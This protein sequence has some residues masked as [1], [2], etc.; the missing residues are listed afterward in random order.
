IGTD[1]TGT[2]DLGNGT[3][4]VRIQNSGGN[5]VGCDPAPKV[6]TLA[7]GNLIS[8]NNASGIAMFNP[9]F[10]TIKGN[11][12]GTD[13]S[14]TLAL[15]NTGVGLEVQSPGNVIGCDASPALCT[16]SEGNLI[17][18]NNN[19]GMFLF[20][21]SDGTIIKGNKIGTDTT[22]AI[23]VGNV[24]DGIGIQSSNNTIGC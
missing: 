16:T 6:C 4:G 18:G 17:S 3:D 22:G 13:V 20:V 23:D 12:I 14:G 8:G 15:G 24:L 19:F 10:N 5:I 1:V 21:G 7:E 9:G 11:K 2:V